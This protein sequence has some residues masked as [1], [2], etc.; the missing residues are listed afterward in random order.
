MLISFINSEGGVLT[1]P[2]NNKFILNDWAGFANTSHSLKEN[3]AP[4]QIG[5]TI[6]NRIFSSRVIDLQFRMVRQNRQNLFNLR[7]EVI[8][9][10]NPM[11]GQGKIVWQQNDG[12]VFQI[13]AELDN[14]QMPSGDAQ[15]NTFQEV[16][17]SFLAEDPRW[18]DFEI[19][20]IDLLLD[21]EVALLNNG[22]TKT[23]CEIEITGPVK[24]PKIYNLTSGKVIIINRELLAGEKVIV[25]TEFGN[26]NIS[27]INEDG[28]NRRAMSILDLDSELFYL[29]KGTNSLFCEGAYTTEETDFKIKFYNRYL[30][31]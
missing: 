11:L 13:N 3:K 10:L 7:R 29:E 4:E 27:F 6:I 2:E 23:H 5:T 20:E 22:D 15:S 9:K 12:T 18:Y 1:L 26:K 14:L 17:V 30:G 21:S 25:N 19:T 8:S 28:Q 16:Q 24:N 31:V